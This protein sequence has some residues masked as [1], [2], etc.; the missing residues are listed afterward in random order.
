MVQQIFNNENT[1]DLPY[2]IESVRWYRSYPYGFAFWNIKAAS[3]P[4]TETFWLPI[5]P[6][7]IN[8]VTH[9]ATNIITTLYG[10][11]EEHSE[12]RYYDIIIQGNTGIAPKYT[13]AFSAKT[14]VPPG[15][16]VPVPGLS[17]PSLNPGGPSG[18]KTNFQPSA[19][20]IALSSLG[21]FL[22]EVTNTISAAANL[23]T[24]AFGETNNTGI[25]PEQSGYLAFHN[26][27]KFLLRYKQDT[28]RETTTSQSV[29]LSTQSQLGLG[30][31]DS[32]KQ[33]PLQFLNY[34]DNIKYDVIPISFTLSRSADSPWLYNYNIKL[35]AFN[36]QNVNAKPAFD[37]VAALVGL[38]DLSGS[39]FSKLTGY[40]GAA[41]TLIS[42]LGGIL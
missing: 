5:S 23:I 12:V 40:V 17:L 22:P 25:K 1:A 30:G 8:I 33:Y 16:P 3:G 38:D 20:D 18:G 39:L 4:A 37:N 29:A 28:S 26:F 2:T 41:A 35:R 9:F 27:Y 36:L 42:G 10:I 19:L 34:K 24:G 32:R 6:N 14:A 13:T 7:N 15:A 21:G 31:A 11:V